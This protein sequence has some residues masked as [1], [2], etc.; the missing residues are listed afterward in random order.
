MYKQ[1]QNFLNEREVDKQLS[2]Q[3]QMNVRI[4][5]FQCVACEML[6]KQHKLNNI[7]TV[8]VLRSLNFN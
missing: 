2:S 1:L 6:T 4:N 7:D 8:A 3:P 5:F